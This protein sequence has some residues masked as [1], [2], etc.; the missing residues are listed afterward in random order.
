M[1]QSLQPVE[2]DA[3]TENTKPKQAR[4]IELATGKVLPS[5]ASLGALVDALKSCVLSDCDDSC[6]LNRDLLIAAALILWRDV[7]SP[8]LE[9]LESSDAREL[10]APFM[11]LLGTVLEAIYLVFT[12]ADFD[13]LLLHGQVAL[14]FGAF[15]LTT[16]IPRHAAGV[17]RRVL[18]R[19]NEYRDELAL[20]QSFSTAM[21]DQ[22]GTVPNR[23]GLS[24]ATLSFDTFSV[25][26]ADGGPS[27][28][29][30][31]GGG[32]AKD[33]DV[34]VPGTGA[35]FGRLHQDLCCV[36]VD[37]LLLL[38]RAELQD[39]TVT[40]TLSP[41]A[42]SMK[43]GNKDDDGPNKHLLE[44]E[45]RL[46]SLCRQNGYMKALLSIQRL[47]HPLT[48]TEERLK[49]ADE[50]LKSLRRVEVHER[51]LQRRASKRLTPSCSE[52]RSKSTT[53]PAAPV[54]IARSSSAVTIQIVEFIPALPAQ[55]K[56]PVH[57][58][59]VYAKLAGAGTAVSLNNN[60]LPG[61]ATPIYPESG[62]TA[63]I[64]GLAPNESY[65]FAVA[66]FDDRCELIQGIGET[67]ELVT[68]LNPLPLPLCY[69]YL[70]QACHE[71]QLTEHARKAANYL[72][73]LVVSTAF[74]RWPSWRASPIY[75]QALRRE[76]VLRLPVPILDKC[77]AAMEILCR[78]EAGDPELEGMLVA[79]DPDASSLLSAHVS[80]L[81]SARRIS[82]GVE[83][84]SAA[85]NQAMVNRLCF[86]GYRVLL[87]L[88]HLSSG[89]GGMAY[90]ALMTFLQVQAVLVSDEYLRAL[91][92]VWILTVSLD[93]VCLPNRG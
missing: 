14:S 6:R 44:T 93:P 87:P 33:D 88:L 28:Q 77:A 50:C 74:A 65:V 67:S 13:D 4:P 56:R 64:F 36:Q 29:P 90:P 72:Y 80:V 31:D 59:M 61:T 38:Y 46:L 25:V 16:K 11:R 42:L 34:G 39:A 47:Y 24:N 63:T 7:A 30:V 5:E 9:T 20:H 37:L 43:R 83:I 17:V 48:T 82:I 89:C 53:V 18:E 66:A 75:R 58:Y 85:V 62:M 60:Q 2:S 81:E 1:R 86:K 8:L 54:V 71:L 52:A 40:N 41:L 35:Q 22:V 15:L 68:A 3:V 84:A 51:D 12:A 32:K 55:R 69:G 70:A 27:S 79:R 76:I 10:P 19:I 73:D 57:C 45:S 78:D 26:S 21:M 91:P 49:I 23:R 92:S